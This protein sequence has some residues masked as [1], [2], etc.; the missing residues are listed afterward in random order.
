MNKV[1]EIEKSLKQSV[2]EISE[3]KFFVYKKLEFL[4]KNILLIW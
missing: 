1:N 4:R 2:K 3:I